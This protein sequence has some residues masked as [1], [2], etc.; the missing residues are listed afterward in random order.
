MDDHKQ[1]AER[2][3]ADAERY[4][5]PKPANRATV[6]AVLALVELLQSGTDANGT[7]C[8]TRTSVGSRT[9]SSKTNGRGTS[10]RRR[11]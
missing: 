5:D 6:H 4:N 2:E 11:T 7:A 10:R 1:E 3:L 8:T 9:E